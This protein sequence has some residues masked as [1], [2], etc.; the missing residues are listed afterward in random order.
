MLNYFQRSWNPRAIDYF[1]LSV[2]S[3]TNPPRMFQQMLKGMQGMQVPVMLSSNP[4]LQLST[5]NQ[6]GE[7]GDPSPAKRART[8]DSDTWYLWPAVGSGHCT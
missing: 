1:V 7:D 3:T 4:N 2:F 8:T 6:S 5:G